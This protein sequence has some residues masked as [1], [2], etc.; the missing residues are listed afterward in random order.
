[1]MNWDTFNTLG[2]ISVI[3]WIAVPVL[4]ALHFR[5]RPRRWLCHIALL[6][7]VAAV[8]L[9]ESNSANHVN[10]IQPD[11]SQQLAALEAEKDA[12]RQ[13]ALDSRGADVADIRF[14]EDGADDFLDRAGMDESE[15]KYTENLDK[16]VQ[17]EWK[18]K[19]GRSGT[20]ED[21]DSLEGA[22]GA[23]EKRA[24]LDTGALEGV[25]GKEPIM[26]NPKDLDMANRLD[27]L[28]IRAAWAMAFLALAMVVVDYLRRA[29]VYREAYL[30]LPLP[31]AWINPASPQEVIFKRPGPARRGIPGELAWMAKRGEVFLYLTGDPQKAEA[32]PDSLPRFVK[33]RWKIDLIRVTGGEGTLGD[34][35]VF[36]TLW[37][38]RSSFV[39]D[40]ADRAK[41]MLLNFLKALA[42]RRKTRSRVAQTVHIVWDLDEPVPDSF[43]NG[44]ARL[45]YDTGFTLF[46]CNPPK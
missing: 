10:L 13:A 17:P 3:L 31:S 41:A 15:L 45:G 19:K 5:M 36:E 46:I 38:G 40:S 8:F 37:Y 21:D 7:A 39:V 1:M 20:T 29:N 27:F 35:F 28:N 22:I 34:G 16:P 32:L 2:Y 11:R 4:L 18:K 9:A 23:N 6:V 30:P 26:M 24:D 33:K 43:T 14:A 44:F 42:E 25:A 12:K